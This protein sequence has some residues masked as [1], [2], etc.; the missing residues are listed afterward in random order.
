MTFEDKE[1]IKSGQQRSQFNHF[2]VI[3]SKKLKFHEMEARSN[4]AVRAMET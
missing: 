3:L 4:N 1:D 2:P